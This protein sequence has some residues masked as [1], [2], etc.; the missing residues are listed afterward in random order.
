MGVAQPA[1][2]QGDG[3]ARVDRGVPGLLDGEAVRATSQLAAHEVGPALGGMELGERQGA[4][5]P[6]GEGRGAAHVGAGELAA[7]LVDPPDEGVRLRGEHRR[8][9][10]DRT[11]AGRPVRER[12][13]RLGRG[14]RVA[15]GEHL[16]LQAQQ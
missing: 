8:L 5:E 9:G 3:R 7:S 4:L 6:D 16:G 1:G 13:Q 11:A 14:A 15:T 12:G 2:V 10:P